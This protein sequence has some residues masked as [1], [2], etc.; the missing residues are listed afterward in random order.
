[1]RNLKNDFEDSKDLKNNSRIW[2]EDN[3]GNIIKPIYAE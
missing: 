1:M 3:A 2:G